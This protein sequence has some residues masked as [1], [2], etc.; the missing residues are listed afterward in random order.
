MPTPQEIHGDGN[1]HICGKPKAGE[2][3]SVC[4]YPHGMVPDK[5]VDADHPEGFWTW[6][7]PENIPAPG[8]AARLTAEPDDDAPASDAASSS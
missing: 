8:Q 2:G 3:N 6:K 4:S 7:L 5:A 1:C